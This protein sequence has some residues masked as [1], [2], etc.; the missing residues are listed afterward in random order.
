MTSSAAASAAPDRPAPDGPP[1]ADRRP[2][3]TEHHGRTRTDDYDWLRA[4]DDPDVTAYLEA[5]NAWT[6]ARTA[7]LADLRT[8]L[9]EEIR[10]RTKETDLSVP[11]RNRGW[12]YYGRSFEGREY[13]A[14]CRVPVNDEADW[15][16]P[17]PAEDCDPDEPA[18]PG[19]QV[20]LDHADGP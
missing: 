7:H 1:V 2:V 4:K 15:T 18:L 9:F 17:V 5:E 11:S 10:A 20:M 6:T 12:W 8:Q 14:A 13:G 16:P 3:T 19:E